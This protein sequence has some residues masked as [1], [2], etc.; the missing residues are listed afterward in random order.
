[1][2]RTKEQAA[3]DFT[4]FQRTI[5]SSDIVIFSDG[6]RLVDGRAGGGYIGFQAHHQFLRSSLSYG[7]GKEVFDAEAEAALAGAQAAIAYPTAQFATNLWI[8]LDNLEVATRLLS[9]ST[10]SSQEATTHKSGSIQIRWVP[11][12]T[13]IPENEA[14]D[15]AAKEG[16]ASI[17][18][19]SYKSSYASLKRYAKTQSLSAAQSQWEKVAPQSYQD[20]EITTSPKRPGELQLNRL[21]LGRIIAARTGHGDF[22][23]YHERF[24]HDDAYLLCRCGARKAPLH[25]FFCHIAKRLSPSASWAPF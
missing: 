3:A 11:G 2:G 16:A 12:H 8:C 9:P 23:D 6:S 17:P 10:G 1:M 24:N 4:A 22:A 5:P 14:A 21:D 25:F 15:L 13:I 7:H 20:L 19:S 18:P